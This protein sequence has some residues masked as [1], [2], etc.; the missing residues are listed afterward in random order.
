[1]YKLLIVDDNQVQIESILR[2][3]DWEALSFGEIRTALDGAEGL[4]IALEFK[5]DVVITDVVMPV[6]DGIEMTQKIRQ[7]RPGTKFIYISCHEDFQYLKNA[8]EDDVFMYVLKPIDEELLVEGAKKAIKAIENDK[9]HFAMKKMMDE[10]LEVFRENFLHSLLYTEHVDDAHLSNTISNLEFDNF[11]NFL[12]VKFEIT[13]DETDYIY[14]SRILTAVREG[15]LTNMNG[16]VMVKSIDGIIAVLMSPGEDSDLFYDEVRQLLKEMTA[17]DGPWKHVRIGL[18]RVHQ[19]LYDMH[20]MLLQARRALEKTTNQDDT[21]LLYEELE[22]VQ[23]E[24]D[25]DDLKKA[26]NTVLDEETLEAVQR[27]LNIYYPERV[28]LSSN[29]IK[30]LCVSTITTLWLLLIE[31]N[32]NMKDIFSESSIVWNKLDDLDS[33]PNKRQWLYN[34]FVVILQFIRDSEKSSYDRII[35]DIMSNINK[36]YQSITNIDKVV[37]DLLISPSYARSIFKKYTGQT[38]FDYL[39]KRRM[40]V[41]QQLLSDPYIKVY[42]VAELVGYS[43]KTHFAENFKRY[44]GKTPKDYQRRRQEKE[45]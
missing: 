14:V 28:R 41:A 4:D 43:S 45:Q 10:S 32:L 38:I 1:M 25:L 29:Y 24:L 26:I 44:T 12:V 39:L 9:K 15:L 3:V 42:E 11:R 30:T 16:Y 5:P 40:E 22:E 31:R 27:F 35:A 2:F 23:K 33:V 20:V 34:I 36:N 21:I 7:L 17:G 6:M 19:S 37:E 13:S 18:S 8:I